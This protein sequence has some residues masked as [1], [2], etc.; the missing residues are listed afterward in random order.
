MRRIFALAVLL[1]IFGISFLPFATPPPAQAINITDCCDLTLVGDP[2]IT[3]NKNRP[4]EL[5]ILARVASP[6]KVL[7]QGDWDSPIEHVIEV[8]LYL[9]S[10]LVFQHQLGAFM[11][12]IPK[13]K[14]G[15]HFG[16]QFEWNNAPKNGGFQFVNIL[17]HNNGWQIGIDV[18]DFNTKDTPGIELAKLQP[19]GDVELTLVIQIDD[20]LICVTAPAKRGGNQLRMILPNPV[21]P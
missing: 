7:W 2:T 21:K 15:F 18:Y 16:G 5:S 14:E 13:N 10:Q 1:G 8:S 6:D 19:L 4:D 3:F 12:T 20:K 11:L 17:R 9:G